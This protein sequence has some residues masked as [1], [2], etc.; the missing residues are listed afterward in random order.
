MTS[1]NYDLAG[2][3]VFVA[4]HRGMVGSAIVRRLVQENCQILVA[5]RS[6]LNLLNEEQTARWFKQNRPDVVVLAA[7]KVG[8]IGANS[9]L[10][11]DFLCENLR[12]ELNVIQ[13]SHDCNVDR[14]L[15]LG[16][17]CIYPKYAKQP[18]HEDELLTGPLEPTNEWYAIAKIA[19]LKM[20]Q[21]YRQQFGDDFIAAM[22]TNLYGPGD[23]YHPEHS[24]V[25]AALLR[26]FHEA[27][28]SGTASVSVW[29]T[30]APL[31]EF[32]YVDDMADACVFL[33]K[34]Y[35]DYAPVNVG[36]GDE[37]SIGQ[38]AELVAEIVGYGGSLTFDTAKP[39]G[40]PR[41]LLDSSRIRAFGWSPK[42]SLRDGLSNAFSDFLSGGGRRLRD[43]V[44][45]SGS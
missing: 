14:L 40:T 23:N 18:I 31:R 3:K 1:F 45:A 29:G 34:R 36:T 16:S 42:T 11:V 44:T 7:A 43:D 37:V 26:R 41:K 12:I 17:S 21:A 13:A 32:L 24:H 8:G 5:D 38:F 28:L 33:L 6:E 9:A 2:K 39:D 19:G 35:S 25:P 30:G 10:P 27:K 15:F 4:G 22:P 20:C